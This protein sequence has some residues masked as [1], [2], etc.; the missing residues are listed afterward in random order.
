MKLLTLFPKKFSTQLIAVA[1][2]SGLIPIIIFW[3][4]IN[5]FEDRFLTEITRAVQK[6]QEE[7]WE[8][9]GFVLKQMAQDFIRRKALDVALQLEL[10]LRH[11]PEMTIRELQND[12]KFREIAVQPVGKTGYTAVFDTDT[13][14]C[15][16]HKNPETENS[17][18]LSVVPQLPRFGAIFGASLGGRYAHGYYKWKEPDGRLQDKYMYIVPLDEGTE[19]GK[20][21]GVA[22][23]SY[24][25]DFTH[26]L[27]AAQDISKST[28]R[29][30]TIASERVIRSFRDM[31]FMF[32]AIGTVLVLAIACLG[33]IYL[34]RAITRLKEATKEVDKGNYDVY[35][36]PLAFGE[37][38][39]LTH[40]FN[41]M[42]AQLAKTTVRKDVLERSEQ[43]LKV[44]N[45]LLQK[46]IMERK[47]AEE[48]LRQNEEQIKRSL[49]E[50]EALLLEVHHRVK[51]NLQVISSLLEMTRTRCRIPEAAAVLSDA[52]ARIHTMA[53]I[54]SEIYRTDR[55]DRVDMSRH[56]QALIAHT[57]QIYANRGNIK[58]FLD[59]KDINLPLTKAVPCALVMN[60][61]IT[62]AFKH[63][64]PDK[65]DGAVTV[66][67]GHPGDSDIVLVDVSDNGC[68]IPDDVD[69][70]ETETL[71]LKLIRNLVQKQLGGKF[72]I[73][74][75]NGT[76]A[77]FEF[78][79]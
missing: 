30:L 6:G 36:E 71:G 11:H 28:T 64:F 49:Q 48:I 78:K 29:Y 68:G 67:I 57:S 3:I 74:R 25:A 35:V 73:Q 27:Q 33:G 37:V 15:W 42:V 20:Q 5:I 19:D 46:E 31:G 8:R 23:T 65:K 7:Q 77:S 21:L 41:R 58:T 39:D 24:V 55:F 16:F 1:L 63:A 47:R 62:N 13:G 54:H 38:K 10:Y 40:H 9:S 61:L 56:T 14:I 60:E 72:W 69:V 59:L 26:S 43:K 22:A 70:Y 44:A 75:E 53:T 50:K 76:K 12:S 32:M 51:N 34:S 18:L 17:N 4:S 45:A 2:A 52:R 66:S 79:V